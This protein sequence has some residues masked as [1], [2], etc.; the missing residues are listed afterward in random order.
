MPDA[1]DNPAGDLRPELPR[2]GAALRR[3]RAD[4]RGVRTPAAHLAAALARRPA[5]PVRGAQP[6]V[7][8]AGV[9][10]PR[11]DLRDDA[12]PRSRRL[13]LRRGRG[14][15][16]GGVARA[17]DRRSRSTRSARCCP[18][19]RWAAGP[20]T[21][22]GSG[23]PGPVREGGRDGRPAGVR[24]P[25]HRGRGAAG[26]SGP[27]HRRRHVGAAARAT[28]GGCRTSSPTARADQLVP[29]A[30]VVEQ[31]A[32][33]DGA[34][35]APPLR[36]VSRRSTT[37]PGRPPTCSP[38]PPRT[39]A[40]G[41]GPAIPGRIT[42]SW[43]PHLR[44]PELGIGPTGVYWVRGLRARNAGP[45]CSPP[46]TSPPPPDPT[47]RSPRCGRP[48]RCVT[49]DTPP[50]AGTFSELAWQL[51]ARPAPQ[52][53]ITARLVD[54]AA[55]SFTLGRAGI[56]P[57]QTATISVQT[58]GPTTLGLTGLAPGQRGPGRR[59]HA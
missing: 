18:A 35:A 30:G 55:L 40:P 43:F 58:D 1:D 20:P 12:R 36:A 21:S 54:V 16:L 24:H 53:R 9:R 33:I 23:L 10:A 19:T 34:G 27:V 28:P 59:P 15:L 31:V 26:R 51:G 17:R 3:V 44:R 41:S 11:V 42:Y 50:V 49:S 2:P 46:S 25:R 5:Q 4:R 6:E 37:S 14:R 57:G 47:R 48:V 13:V 56:A 38:R 29:V 22:S 32:D 7:P 52:R 45:V 39:W 8:P